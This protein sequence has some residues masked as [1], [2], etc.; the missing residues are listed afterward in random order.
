[1]WSEVKY[2]LI[3]TA[4]EMNPLDKGKKSHVSIDASRTLDKTHGEEII[5]MNSIALVDDDISF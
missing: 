5:C 2:G 4:N 3:P 1:M